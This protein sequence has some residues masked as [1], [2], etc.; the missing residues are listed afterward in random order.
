MPYMQKQAEVRCNLFRS[1]RYIRTKTSGHR[2]PY[3]MPFEMEN[4]VVTG[5]LQS[6]LRKYGKSNPAKFQIRKLG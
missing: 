3:T 1:M 2:C 4:S 5:L 6:M